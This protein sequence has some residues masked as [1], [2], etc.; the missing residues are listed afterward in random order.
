MSYVAELLL[1]D[2][3]YVLC[4]SCQ[5]MSSAVAKK[6]GG[7]ST[8]V[9]DCVHRLPPV[10]CS[11]RGERVRSNFVLEVGGNSF[12]V[13]VCVCGCDVCCYDTWPS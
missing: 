13:F 11:L 3:A 5:L 6:R 10:I 2:H 12:E 9:M 1:R 7:K 4:C 8:L